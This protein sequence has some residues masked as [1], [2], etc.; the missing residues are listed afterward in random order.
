MENN[1]HEKILAWLDGDL[2][3]EERIAFEA[4]MRQNPELAGEVRL[5]KEALHAIGEP[6]VVRL[7]Q[8]LSE[9]MEEELRDA[10]EIPPGQ[11][12]NQ[13]FR[14]WWVA[15]LLILLAAFVFWNLKEPEGQPSAPPSQA[16][17]IASVGGYFEPPEPLLSPAEKSKRSEEEEN[18]RESQVSAII[19]VVNDQFAA[20]QFEAALASLD[21]LA[22]MDTEGDFLSKTDFLNSKGILLLQLKKPEEALA[23]LE[24]SLKIR[25]TET[26]AW[27]KIAALLTLG[28]TD[29]AKTAL[30]N[31]LSRPTNPFTKKAG[32]ILDEITE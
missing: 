26:G 5:A 15:A 3:E 2:P 27:Y 10:P 19:K 32:I 13:V 31:L 29:E 11:N 1:I 8:Q 22:N 23:T 17:P 16:A 20:G 24:S 18:E 12:R 25:P 7:R 21:Q 28:R 30:A 6:S 14:Y 9:I 4:E